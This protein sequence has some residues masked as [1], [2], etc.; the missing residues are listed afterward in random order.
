MGYTLYE[1][2]NGDLSKDIYQAI[3]ASRYKEYEVHVLY[4]IFL[5]LCNMLLGS[6]NFLNKQEKNM[7]DLLH[8]HHWIELMMVCCS[9][10]VTDM[11]WNMSRDLFR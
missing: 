9:R 1:E 7:C 11:G 2:S 8:W 4:R 6:S 10:D 3:E 5:S